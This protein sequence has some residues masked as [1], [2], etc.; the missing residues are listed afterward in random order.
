MGSMGIF[1]VL[2]CRSGSLIPTIDISIVIRDYSRNEGVSQSAIATYGNW[3]KK[4]D[5]SNQRL[6]DPAQK[7][8]LPEGEL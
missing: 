1:D 8:G 5:S 2:S 6:I 3:R 7:A 4:C